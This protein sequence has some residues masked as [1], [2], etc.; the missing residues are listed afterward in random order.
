MAASG[1]SL[2]AA[3]VAQRLEPSEWQYDDWAALS[4]AVFLAVLFFFLAQLVQRREMAME[5]RLRERERALSA[6][7]ADGAL[8]ER[9]GLI[10]INAMKTRD[11]TSRTADH[12]TISNDAL[13]ALPLFELA[14]PE[15]RREFLS[16]VRGGYSALAL[17][18]FN[19]GADVP[20]AVS[21]HLLSGAEQLEHRLL[22]IAAR[23]DDDL[24][25]E[26]RETARHLAL[27]GEW[28]NAWRRPDTDRVEASVSFLR[29]VY[30]PELLVHR[31]WTAAG[32]DQLRAKIVRCDLDW[33][34][35]CHAPLYVRRRAEGH[36]EVNYQGHDENLAQLG[37]R[38]WRS[39]PV[40][41]SHATVA[42]LDALRRRPIDRMRRCLDLA[43]WPGFSVLVYEISPAHRVVLDGNHR[44]AAALRARRA[45]STADV[46]VTAFVLVETPDATRAMVAPVY[47]DEG[48]LTNRTELFNPDAALL[49]TAVERGLL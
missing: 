3:V 46:S 33:L 32:T 1:A 2:A 48:R 23:A 9:T 11:V 45:G 21:A 42:T 17:N 40:P 25:G 14:S 22:E 37:D 38:D 27:C 19:R 31:N 28:A 6:A 24:A 29:D 49:R 5:A 36:I 35:L 30:E 41:L 47:D 7:Q 16:S 12:W 44:T 26:M 20:R 43:A 34:S 4:M 8:V 39:W 18:A 10:S 15:R 13:A